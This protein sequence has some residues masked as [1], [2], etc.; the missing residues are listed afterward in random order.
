MTYHVMPAIS[1]SGWA[2]RKHGA[3]RATKI[4]TDKQDAIDDAKRRGGV[5]YV[6][7]TDGMVEQKINE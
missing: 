2:V 5:V 3:L 6:H 1:S 4:Y 7:R